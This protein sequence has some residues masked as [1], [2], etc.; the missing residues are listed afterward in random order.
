[1]PAERPRGQLERRGTDRWLQGGEESWE[2][3]SY[4][5]VPVPNAGLWACVW[6][7]RII[8]ALLG[9]FPPGGLV[10]PRGKA[11]GDKKDRKTLFWAAS[12]FCS[13]ERIGP[14]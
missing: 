5:A 7:R 9:V 11:D 4:G 6:L 1:M 8:G 13:S 12:T 10:E 3:K 2:N 14:G